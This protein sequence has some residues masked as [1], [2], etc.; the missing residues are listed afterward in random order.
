MNGNT[1]RTVSEVFWGTRPFERLW[2]RKTLAFFNKIQKKMPKFQTERVSETKDGT[3]VII[4]GQNH[5]EIGFHKRKYSTKRCIFIIWNICSSTVVEGAASLA[6]QVNF[7]P[8]YIDNSTEKNRS[9]EA[10]SCAANQ[11]NLHVWNSKIDCHVHNRPPLVCIMS[12]DNPVHIITFHLP[13]S[14]FNI[15]LASTIRSHTFSLFL[16]LSGITLYG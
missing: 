5:A 9:W 16:R 15:I 8:S 2:L 11:D 6:R 3:N 1:L 14:N 10:N 7:V 13:E 12:Q 4:R